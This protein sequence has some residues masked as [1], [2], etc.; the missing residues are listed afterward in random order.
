MHALIK[1]PDVLFAELQPSLLAHPRHMWPVVRPL[2]AILSH[3][4]FGSIQHDP[5]AANSSCYHGLGGKIVLT[6]D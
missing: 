5:H 3:V 4:L 6:C 2:S 1:Y